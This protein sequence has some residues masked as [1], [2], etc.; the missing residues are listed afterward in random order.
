MATRRRGENIGHGK[1]RVEGMT[2]AA[3]IGYALIALGPALALFTALISAK[4]F[5]ILTL[6]SRY[7]ISLQLEDSLCC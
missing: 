5:L 2:V 6:V 3:G 1:K 4:P 7:S